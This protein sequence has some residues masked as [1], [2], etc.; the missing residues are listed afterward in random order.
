MHEFDKSLTEEA[1]FT[2]LD[3]S[4]VTAPMMSFAGRETLEYARGDGWQVVSMP[5]DGGAE[6][7]LVFLPDQGKFA[8]FEQELSA[9]FLDQLLANLQRYDVGLSMPK[10]DFTSEFQLSKTLSDMGMPLA[11]D[12]QRADFSGIDGGHSLYISEV[13]HKAFVAVDEA[14][15]EA[16]AATGVI[17]EPS[18]APVGGLDL[19]LDRPFLFIIR[20]GSTGTILFAGRVLNP[21]D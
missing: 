21:G 20:D 8:E 13:V 1:P 15:T 17:V 19:R 5:Y 18:S 11:F 14:G 6:E 9:S 12:N 10:F 16:A 3:G 4:H 2:R 7:M